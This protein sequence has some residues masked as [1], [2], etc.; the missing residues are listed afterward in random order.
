MLAALGGRR[1]QVKR[2]VGAAELAGARPGES[3]TS[4]TRTDL[5]PNRVARSLRQLVLEPTGRVCRGP[6]PE[7]RA[8]HD[9]GHNGQHPFRPGCERARRGRC[10]QRAASAQQRS[11]NRD[12]RDRSDDECS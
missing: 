12:R 3:G 5:S 4:L 10:G 8:R 9:G 2:E 11:G 7:A 1:D 6:G